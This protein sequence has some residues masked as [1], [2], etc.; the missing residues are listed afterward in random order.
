MGIAAI[1]GA[2]AQKPDASSNYGVSSLQSRVTKLD[3][4]IFD[5]STCT[6]TPA[7]TKATQLANL[8]SQKATVQTQIQALLHQQQKTAEDAKAAQPPALREGSTIHVIA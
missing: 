5:V 3:A 8:N 1:S 4:Q 6:T 2:S 7:K